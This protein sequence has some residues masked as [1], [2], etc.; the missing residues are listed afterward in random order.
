MKR[1]YHLHRI[2]DSDFYLGIALICRAIDGPYWT[3][4]FI[5][6]LCWLICFTEFFTCNPFKI[7]KYEGKK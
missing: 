2:D 3:T 4:T 1:N 5:A 7:Q 6:A